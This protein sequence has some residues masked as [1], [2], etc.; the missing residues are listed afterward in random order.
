MPTRVTPQLEA[1]FRAIDGPRDH[2]T[3]Q[4]VFERVRREIPS[5][6]LS[7]VYRNLEKL[8]RDG[9]LRVLRLES[10]VA[11]YDAV[12]VIH[13]HFLC[14]VC[15]LVVDVDPEGMDATADDRLPG[16][17]IRRRTTTLYGICRDCSGERA[18]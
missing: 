8:T 15:G 16:H 2:P 10:G 13:D 1:V 11:L 9:R 14:D 18:S 3:A 12:E 6:S 17:S 7:T 5:V 4:R